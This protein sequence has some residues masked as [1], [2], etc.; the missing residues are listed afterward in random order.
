MFSNGFIEVNNSNGDFSLKGP[1]SK[2]VNEGLIIEAQ[3]IDGNFSDKVDKKVISFNSSKY[4]STPYNETN[5]I[6]FFKNFFYF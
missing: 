3:F 4:I 2:L 1:N 5:L 6:F